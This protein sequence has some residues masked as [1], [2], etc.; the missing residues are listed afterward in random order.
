[1]KELEYESTEILAE[2]GVPLPEREALAWLNIITATPIN[3]AIA[4]NAASIGSTATAVAGQVIGVGQ[5]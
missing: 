5:L 1:M 4:I 2:E 3:F